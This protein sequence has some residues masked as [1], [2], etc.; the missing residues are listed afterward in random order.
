MR[1]SPSMQLV[2]R[3]AG[4]ESHI[5]RSEHIEPE[6]LFIALCK[7]PD[8]VEASQGMAGIG[9]ELAWIADLLLQARVDPAGTR[10]HVRS[11]VRATK[12]SGSKFSGH[13]SER[14]RALCRAAEEHAEEKSATAAG[15]KHFLTALLVSTSPVLLQALAPQAA[16]WERVREQ[17]GLQRAA[18][19]AMPTETMK[20]SQR[21][22]ARTGGRGRT[23][24][25]GGRT[26]STPF[27]DK[28]G[29]D[30][31]VLARERRL[32][33]CVGRKDEMRQV[34]RI[35][36]RRTKNN[37]VL[38]GDAGVGKTCIVEGLAQKAVRTG[39]PRPLCEWRI[40]E[41]GM[42]TLLAGAKYR[43]EFEQ[44]LE[45]II[46]EASADPN[47][48]LF[49]DELHTMVGAGGG[50]GQ[51]LDAAQ[52]L[53]PALARGEIK[54]VGATTTAEYRKYVESDAALERRFQMVWVNEPSKEEAVEILM[55]LKAGFEGH[56]DVL[57]SDDAVMRAVEWSMR[58][59]PDH[60]LPDKAID[61]LDQ[62]CA[63]RMLVTLSPY[64]VDAAAGG[65]PVAAEDIAAVVAQ[66]CRVPIGMLTADEA[67]RLRGMEHTL[68]R[69]VMGQDHAVREVAEAVRSA[70]LGLK[71][72]HRPAGV[73]LFLG[74]TGVGKT[75]LAKAL[76][77]FLFGSEDA[78]IRFDMSEYKEKHEVSKLIG[79][80]PGYIGHDE[81]GQLVGKVRTRPYSVVLFDE[82]E[83]AHPEVFDLFLQ[84]LDEGRL[85]DAKGR[86]A[87]F[88]EAT[89]IMTSNLGSSIR[90]R[91]GSGQG[92]MGVDVG[93]AR[94]VG[95]GRPS[96]TP[97]TGAKSPG[98]DHEAYARA[99]QEEVRRFFRP[100]LLNRIQRQVVFRWLSK[101]VVRAILGKLVTALNER[102]KDRGITIQLSSEAEDRLIEEGYD[103]TYGARAL[104]RAFEKNVS[105]RLAA[106]LLEDRA[107]EGQRLRVVVD[108]KGD[109]VFRPA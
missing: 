10:R 78:L 14:C 61:L 81:E 68:K 51:G 36:R 94:S 43:G 91:G 101:D 30:L 83:K 38:V 96:V 76:A 12:C 3:L 31:T 95:D 35:L 87:V 64:S 1:L 104:E 47:L 49:I 97:P 107:K 52:I 69:R 42:G 26:P 84:V 103:E 60:R 102:L 7:L 82:I 45:N 8:L 34:A 85:T 18:V 13:R 37:P 67:E 46:R 23:P 86:R 108:G 40:V 53:K 77:E 24:K 32:P 15:L 57:I 25:S 56:H 22:D 79:A 58:Y 93:E 88:T 39:A 6:H 99:I 11:L 74:P 89:I 66:K 63:T 48:I 106:D 33:P 72:P 50:G 71:D 54:V 80:P 17:L 109:Y 27:L 59:M 98:A 28:F 92:K 73:F 5:C 29:R 90:A 55:G 9:D 20:G 65:A 2:F 105:D 19:C 44:R 75:E 62:A 70:R 4:I 41:L 100:E 16:A 21:R